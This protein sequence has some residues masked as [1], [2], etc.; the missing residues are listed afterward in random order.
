MLS[1][2]CFTFNKYLMVPFIVEDKELIYS[3]F[4]ALWYFTVWLYHDS[5]SQ[6][7]KDGHVDCLWLA[8]FGNN[9]AMN[10]LRHSFLH[11]RVSVSNRRIYTFLEVELWSQNAPV[12]LTEV[13]K[14]IQKKVVQVWIPPSLTS[15]G[16]SPCGQGETTA[17]FICTSLVQKWNSPWPGFLLCPVVCPL[18]VLCE[19]SLYYHY[20]YLPWWL[21]RGGTEPAKGGARN[22]ELAQT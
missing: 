12:I 3:F 11:P 22:L 1:C 16:C 4:P 18:P 14:C 2:A 17:G 10:N 6:A 20:M 8:G 13:S 21:A 9:T 15:A 19:D 5:F 7:P